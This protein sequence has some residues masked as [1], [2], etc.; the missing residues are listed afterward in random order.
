MIE[1]ILSY[2]N[3]IIKALKETALLIGVSG[4]V[5]LIFGFLLGTLIFMSRK[6]GIKENVLI[7]TLCNTYVNIVRSFPFLIFIVAMMP[8]TRFFLGRSIGTLP[9]TLPLSLVGIAI[10]S[11]FVEQSL[12]E[13]SDDTIETAHSMGASTP[14][15]IK[16]FLLVESRSS[17]VLGFTSSLISIISY[18]TVMGVV[19]GGGIGD[20]AMRYGYQGMDYPLMYTIVFLIIVGVQCI[21]ITGT[22][23]AR[24][25]Q[26]Y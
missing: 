16:H 19:G 7:N 12:L 13:V 10:F 21:Q 1:H 17:L 25:I 18:S 4:T 22:L 20:F 26:K 5:S 6:G 11:R 2:Q 23:I 15:I 9:A 14:Q 3:E 24:K 8:I